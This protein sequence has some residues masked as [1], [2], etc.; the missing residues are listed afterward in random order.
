LITPHLTQLAIDKGI[1]AHS[2]R[3]L[4]M[5]SAVYVAAFLIKWYAQYWQTIANITLGQRVVY[6]IRTQLFAHIQNQA[7]EF[8]DKR[9]VGRLI[10]RLVS[11]TIALNGLLSFN[12]LSTVTHILT[13]IGIVVIM[14]H[15]DLQLSLMTFTLMPVVCYLTM[16]FGRKQRL[17]YREVR[18]K[19]ATVT[20]HL[21]ENVSGVKAVKSFTREKEN[22]QRFENVNRDTRDTIM[23]AVK[24]NAFYWPGV[25]VIAWI[26][27][28]F[29]YWYAGV[30]VIHHQ[31]S[32][33]LL[34][35]FTG[36]MTGFFGPIQQLSMMYQ[37][38]QDAMVGAER[39]FKIFDTHPAV[40]DKPDA[41]ELPAIR[42]AVSFNDVGFGY[43][44]TPVLSHVS[45][46][47]TP[48]QT[49][50]LVGPTGAGKST[51]VNLL[52]RQYDVNT[53][54]VTID[55]FDVR[56]I[57]MNSLRQQ[58]GVVLQESYL[59]PGSVKDN[60]RYGRLT[61]TDQEVEAAAKAVGAHDFITELPQGYDTDVREG[62]SKLSVGQ[63]QVLS[64]ARALVADPR[65]LILDEAT[66]S[67]DT[68]TEVLIQN[69]LRRLLKGRT[70]FVIA[71]RLSTITGADKILVINDGKLAESGP[72]QELLKQAGIYRK[73]HDMQFADTGQEETA[74]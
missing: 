26:G 35:A 32:L 45:F 55:G 9:E 5:V 33:G 36:Y 58:M 69:A 2:V 65:I 48:G 30:K 73:L 17:I 70:S 74:G 13:V 62:G 52:A 42:G 31:M 71:H 11:D 50:A 7:L 38:L 4:V 40:T 22:L 66:S 16:L 27:I 14:V 54:S 20:A 10:S 53:G 6:G 21:A 3:T 60:I 47:A 67:V 68:Q 56:D 8:F 1:K 61:A 34:V 43:G 25:E 19:V 28:A 23:Q 64:F 44:D 57:T 29:V 12:S 72:H 37:T 59:F 46:A 15:K 24:I 41:T 51:I 39:I 63:K 49:I 18:K